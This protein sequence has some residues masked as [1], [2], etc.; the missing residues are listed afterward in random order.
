MAEV[1]AI[2]PGRYGRRDMILCPAR[3]SHTQSLR[4]GG[5]RV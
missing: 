2:I 5:V 3:R 1:E 4:G